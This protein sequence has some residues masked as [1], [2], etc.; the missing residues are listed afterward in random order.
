MSSAGD[1]SWLNDYVGVP[2]VENGRGRDGWDCWGLVLA[3][4]RDRL[5][6]ELPDFHWR[7]PFGQ[8]AKLRAFGQA[9]AG[10][11]A[12][13]QAL[14]LEAPEAWSIGLLYGEARPHHVG[15]AIGATPSALGVLH[16]RRYGGT[17]F[18]PTR[19]FLLMS[20]RAQWFR[21]RR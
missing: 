12:A 8:A 5:G 6:L 21:W 2:F 13:D 3:V 18:E 11:F 10:V 7:A 1:L 9:V 20:T 19:R 16:A 4:Y 15:V 17:V 14:E